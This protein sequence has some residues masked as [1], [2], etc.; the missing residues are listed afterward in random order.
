MRRCYEFHDDAGNYA[1]RAEAKARAEFPGADV[2]VGHVTSGTVAVLVE[3]TIG[4]TQPDPSAK[5]EAP[6]TVVHIPGAFYAHYEDGRITRLVFMP[7]ASDAGYA[8]PPATVWDGDTSLDVVEVEGPFWR[9]MQAALGSPDPAE[10]VAI[11]WEE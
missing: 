11:E 4:T 10:H 3:V 2:T 8:G 6:E 1:A 9:A 5:G 7:H